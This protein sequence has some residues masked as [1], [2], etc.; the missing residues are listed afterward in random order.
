MT[1]ILFDYDMVG[2]PNMGQNIESVTPKLSINENMLEELS[3]LG[4]L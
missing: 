4:M 1:V 2:R 3:L